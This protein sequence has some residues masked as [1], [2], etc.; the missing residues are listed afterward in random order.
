[1]DGGAQESHAGGDAEV[2]DARRIVTRSGDAVTG[3]T[4]SKL[5]PRTRD[6]VLVAR[7]TRPWNSLR[8]CHVLAAAGLFTVIAA[9]SGATVFDPNEVVPETEA[10]DIHQITALIEARVRAQF[11]KDGLAT[12]DAHAKHHGCVN[13]SFSVLDNLPAAYAVGV[14]SKPGTYRAILRLSNGMGTPKDDRAGDARGFALKLLDVAGEKVLEDEREA[15][16]QDFVMINHS[17]FFIRNVADYV[18][19]S[20]ASESGSPLGFFF[21]WNPFNWHLKE[22]W[23]A[24]SIRSKAVKNPLEV[25]YASTTPILMGDIPAK[26]AVTPSEGQHFV[27]VP[28]SPNQLREA[29]ALQ[30]EPNQQAQGVRFEFGVQLQTDKDRMPVEDATVE[31]SEKESPYKTVAIIDIPR[32]ELLNKE[33]LTKCEN[34]SFTPW[35]ALLDHRPIG[36]IQ[37]ARRGIY[38][39]ISRVRHELNKQPRKEP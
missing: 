12:R 20:Q 31:W 11:E 17:V 29:L 21:G 33:E 13:A 27:K 9:A 34:L 30:L 7:G 1:M 39:T 14:F 6:V 38:Q 32:Q 5:K 16:T 37:R 2:G 26:Y 3:E 25:R 4:M 35:H 15:T 23:I 18:V 24:N 36:G 8:G 28:S 10:Q 22:A 19:F